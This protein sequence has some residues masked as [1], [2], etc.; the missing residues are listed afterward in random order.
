METTPAT[1]SLDT[2]VPRIL[3]KFE[4]KDREVG[5]ANEPSTEYNCIPKHNFSTLLKTLF[6]INTLNYQLF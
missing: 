1:N 6:R 4:W 2:T 5:A 3:D